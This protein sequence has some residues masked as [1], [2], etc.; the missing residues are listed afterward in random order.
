MTIAAHLDGVRVVSIATNVPGPAAASRLCALGARVTKV[1]PPTGDYLA[2]V[3]RDWYRAL[4]AGQEVLVLDLK[5]AAGRAA[6]DDRLASTDVLLTS[7]RPRALARLGLDAAR[8]GA[9]F[10]RL[11]LVMIVGA[12]GEE[13]ETPGHDLT[14]QAGAGLV[15]P[16]Q[17]PLSLFSDLATGE[18]AATAA[19]ALLLR[20]AR[21]GAGGAT[22]VALADVAARLAA[23]RQH[24]LTLPGGILGGGLP[25]Y[26]I[27]AAAHGWVAVAALEPH[28]VA[29]L[30]AGLGMDELTHEGLAAA[31]AKRDAV[32]WE[33]WGK[34]NDVPIAAVRGP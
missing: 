21:S 24:G 18:A 10:P 28:F 8:L 1:E 3:A 25:V 5:T 30:A 19:L 31:F 27:Y 15:T 12:T 7:H 29:R 17:L 13:A 4:C 33:A 20:R 26:A 32:A 34:A 22:E 14:Y 9:D 11:C 16:P 23:P 6:L 2:I